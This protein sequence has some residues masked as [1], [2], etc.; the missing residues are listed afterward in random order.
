MLES[1]KTQS[2]TGTNG[3]ANG[4]GHSH[5]SDLSAGLTLFPDLVALP[6]A[7]TK[8]DGRVVAFDI[9]RIE[10][11]M[12]KCF[13]SLGKKPSTPLPDL[14]TQVVNIVSVKYRQPTVE[15]V[16]D[17]VE[18]VL[19]AAGEYEAAKHYILYRAEHAKQRQERPIP[20][21]VRRAFSE[22]D[23]FFPTQLQKFQFYDKYS[24]F[25][26][27]LG[28]RET[29]IETVD[30]AVAYLAELSDNRLGAETYDRLRR[31][32]LDMRAMP[33][34]RLLAMAGP[35]AR[36]NNI[37][38]Y[39]CFSGDEKLLTREYGV[40]PI[41]DAIGQVTVLNQ[42]RRWTPAEVRSF[43]V[44]ET[45]E[46]EFGLYKAKKRVR[47]T[48]EH[49]WVLI[50]G[51]R[52]RT[53][54]LCPEEKISYITAPRQVEVDSLDYRLGLMHGIVYGDGAETYAQER[55]NGYL[56][57]LC[58]DARELL[59]AFEGYPRSF[60]PSYDGDPVVYL[61][62]DFAKTHRLKELPPENETDDYL[63]GFVRGWFAADGYISKHGQI[64]FATDEAGEAYLRRFGPRV[65]FE[66]GYTTLM[67]DET[68]F[69]VRQK[70]VRNLEVRRA[71]VTEADFIL[72]KHLRNYREASTDRYWKFLG[73]TPDSRR[74]EEVFCAVVPDTHT[75]TLSEGLLTGNCSYQPVESID[76]FVEALIISM[77]GCGVGFSVERRY[78][79]N[80]PRIKRQSGKA[81]INYV[82]ADSAEGWADAL[83]FGLQTWFEGGD[84][85]FDLSQL[86]A[87]GTP[88]LTKG[89]RA[90]GPDPFRR[91]LD[92]ARA[93]I[94]ARQGSFLRP[95]DAHDLMCSVGNAAV[96]GGVRRT[97]MISLFDTDDA[98]MRLSKSGDFE[99]DNNQR[100]NANNSAVW[101]DN[102]Q[103]Q[104]EF[105]RHFMEMVD[106]GRGEPGIF[107]REVANTLK[108]A[109]RAEA[110]FGTNP[111]VTGDTWVAVADGRGRVQI[112]DLVADGKDV[113]VY[114]V[115]DN[116]LVVRTMR[117][118]RQ[119]GTQTPVYRV[120]FADG[121]YIRATLNHRFV[122]LDGSEK[123][124]AE[125]QPQDAL[126]AMTAFSYKKKGLPAV[127]KCD[128][129]L[130][131]SY[132]MIQFRTQRKSEHRRIY[133][134]HTGVELQGIDYQLHHRDFDGRNNHPSNLQLMTAVE[135]AAE[136]RTRMLGANNP[137]VRLMNDT[138]RK[139][140]SEA[141]TGAVNGNAKDI[142]NEQLEQELIHLTRRLGRAL[143][144][145]EYEACARANNWP[146]V[147]QA[148]R[149]NYF[150]GD[151][152][153]TIRH[154]AIELGLP[155]QDAWEV[156]AR[157]VTDLP[158]RFREG[159]TEVQKMCEVCGQP[160]WV[161]LSRREQA[162]C[163]QTCSQ[164]LYYRLHGSEAKRARLIEAHGKR[165]DG[166]R[167]LHVK[168]YN[169]LLSELNRH[170]SKKEWQAYCRQSGISPEISRVSSP[171]RSWAELEVAAGATNHRVVSVIFDG[172]E[173]VYTG[174]VDETHTFF[175][176]GS[177]R[178]DSKGRMDMG[179]VLSWQCGEIN[180]RGW[181]FCNLTA[182]VARVDD[183]FESLKEKVELATIIGSIQSMATHF[184]GLRPMWKEN[185]ED[186]RLLGVDITGQMDSPIA[187]DAVVKEQLRGYA[188]EINQQ[189]ASALGINPSA[190]ITCV[191][192]SGNSSQLL[193]CASGLHARWAPYYIRNV[194]VAAHSPVYKVLRDAGVPMDPENGQIAETANTWV[195]HF[196][197][198]S[199][200]GAITRSMRSAVEQCEY[201]LQNKVYWTEHNPSCFTGE[202]RLITERGLMSFYE[203]QDQIASDSAQMPR[204]LGKDG[205][206]VEATLQ[207]FGP[208]EVW[209]VVVE[210]CG[211][212]HTILTTEDH[213]WPITSPM[214]RYRGSEFELRTT[215]ELPINSK[216][217][218]LV[219]VN[220]R[221]PIQLD[222]EGVLHGITYGD[223][224]QSSGYKGRTRYCSVALCNDPNGVDSRQLADLFIE[225]GYSPNVRGDLGQIQ[226]YGLPTHWKQLPSMDESSEYL[227]GFVAGWFAA[228]GHI[229]NTVTLSN[230][231]R[232]ALEWLQT[233]APR[234][235]LATPTTI[236]QYHS[237][238]GVAPVTY[239]V[240]ALVK[241]ALD[242]DF[243][244]LR[245]KREKF[246]SAKF[247]K[248]WKVVSVRNTGRREPVY[249][250]QVTG[251][252][253]YFT[254]EG[255]ILTHNCTITYHPNEVIDLM[256]WVW[257]HRA[258]IG[259]LSFL[260]AFD[261]NYAQMPY[262][263]IKREEYERLAV[264]FPEIDFAKLYYYEEDDL[265]TAAQELA[266]LA[267]NCE[268]EIV[269][270]G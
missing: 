43:G 263:E 109:R 189:T 190:A 52:A 10:N 87:A 99:R 22:A 210:R 219:T 229:N 69:G 15:Q 201:W 237:E 213:L 153:P 14:A 4:N 211:V 242:E 145:S 20:D 55:S 47:A 64:L 116:D 120:T 157:R 207:S 131:D 45:V 104:Q 54:E 232:E 111:C 261:A 254:L 233:I 105:M 259:G 23:R 94:L 121:S 244:V 158:L 38:I 108:P 60:P 128:Y 31:G 230:V 13:A 147:W 170:P 172:H 127:V 66:F 248:Y 214:R 167:N 163:G 166:L 223:G 220:P 53:L 134:H 143:L 216:D 247:A 100:W 76:S 224:T 5:S 82:V 146:R 252:E 59:S 198:K 138:W 17:I 1:T 6:P 209:E 11:A 50:D 204:V 174:T 175:S 51:A 236:A 218:K 88:L 33:S 21:E 168:V 106:S 133:A 98:E 34:M 181:E 91:M 173:D 238:G 231:C 83:R 155:V 221:E 269:P 48:A 239:H 136:H 228:D 115:K 156:E 110:E 126:T 129:D 71:S 119:T 266:C 187:Q 262:M 80:F 113:D 58:D 203:L 63:I 132:R 194:R 74:V 200:D 142:S 169:D 67:S 8:R 117:N 95:L 258:Q 150:H 162:T 186:E 86:R 235:G 49:E 176:I 73:I 192:P 118:P 212:Q 151:I 183:T 62:D 227:R 206:W 171:F 225:A 137:A 122:M 26:Y 97:A 39:N 265:T 84:V 112:R 253:P 184:P 234:A 16:Q 42:N 164:R 188:I 24:R 32:I 37:A 44:Q 217:Y 35:A 144:R 267:G 70:K 264:E 160:F 40:I 180:L 191:K 135:H 159:R 243:F 36:R 28:R 249:C 140:L 205:R 9:G 41:R 25:N 256:K 270:Q 57:R 246:A 3:K 197:V 182:A 77:S 46:L 125:L 196:P 130:S 7:I 29:W 268:V 245:G 152:T 27:D 260:P 114:T 65:G 222:I 72:S 250:V 193:N 89:G 154:L 149:Q 19:Q 61:Y 202:T 208:Q 179:Y 123:T 141:C 177:E 165:K 240:T 68:N 90:S 107:S 102:R 257:E 78:V 226:F 185:C 178:K 2:S 96:S 30:R 103:T 92:F 12:T 124:T 139:N 101:N 255:N 18:M 85:R 75:F 148:Y 81:P 56:I 93:R 161:K 195:V 241:E 199:P 79:E 215:R 251:A